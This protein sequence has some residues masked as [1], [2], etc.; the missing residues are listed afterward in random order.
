M[1]GG[2]IKVNVLGAEK[3]FLEDWIEQQRHA[4]H[5]IYGV[6]DRGYAGCYIKPCARTGESS[7]PLQS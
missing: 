3:P 6:P 4:G 7:M 2:R 1:V 5:E